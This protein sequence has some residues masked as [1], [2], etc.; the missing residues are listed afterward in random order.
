MNF[1]VHQ[2]MCPIC[3]RET[4]P[5]ARRASQQRFKGHRKW[6]YCPWRKQQVNTYECRSESEKAEFQQMFA[7]G[8]ITKTYSQALEHMDAKYQ[9]S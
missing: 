7:T 9:H 4:I 3:C 1:S 8:K 2:F 5:V 6:L